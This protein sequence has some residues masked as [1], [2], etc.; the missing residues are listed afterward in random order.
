MDATLL[1][2]LVPPCIAY[3]YIYIYIYIYMCVMYT[4]VPPHPASCCTLK[5]STSLPA[6]ATR[7]GFDI[8]S[9]STDNESPVIGS[10]TP[11]VHAFVTLFIL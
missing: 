8:Y 5:I 1:Y 2:T 3:I 6:L 7:V 4:H 9:G 10:N 11:H